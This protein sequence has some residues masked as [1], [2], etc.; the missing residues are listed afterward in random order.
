MRLWGSEEIEAEKVSSAEQQLQS[1]E[2]KEEALQEED[3]EQKKSGDGGIRDAKRKWSKK[4]TE[5]Q[6]EELQEDSTTDED[7]MKTNRNKRESEWGRKENIITIKKDKYAE[8]T[9][10][11][12]T[13]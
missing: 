1:N 10:C 13:E 9:K 3:G 8:K 11:L 2:E 5:Y 6:D 4:S 12:E 7:G